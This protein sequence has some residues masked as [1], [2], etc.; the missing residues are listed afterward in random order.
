MATR[1]YKTLKV[2]LEKLQAETEAARISEV[3]A[4]ISELRAKAAEYG[5]TADDVFPP[6]KVK[7]SKTN[8]SLPP[9]YQDPK[10]GL[11]WSGKGRA[12]AWIRDAKNR[13]KFLIQ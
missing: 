6:K 13:D 11:T 7:A 3:K 12:P 5:L 9:K 2:E 10:T 8:G 1:D 4:V